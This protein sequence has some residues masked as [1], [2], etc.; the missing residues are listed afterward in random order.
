MPFNPQLTL[1]RRRTQPAA[2]Y[3]ARLTA[4]ATFAYLLALHVPAGTG[5]PVL[6]PL[7]AVLVLQASLFQTI[8]SGIKKVVSVAAGVLAA[9][10]LST[11]VEFNWWL[12]G[13]LIGAAL[14]IGH[15]L[16]LGDDILEVPIS[17]MLIFSSVGE[18]AAATGRVIDTLVGTAAGLAGGLVFAPLRVQPARE[19]VGELSGRLAELL[20]QMA[21]GLGDEPDPSRVGGWLTQARDLR[22]EIERVDDTLRQAEDSARL[23]PRVLRL[24][25]ALPETEVALRGGLETLERAALTLRFLA[26]SVIDA[27]RADSDASP[28]RDAETRDRLAAVLTRLAAAIRTYGNLVQTLPS[29]DESLQA[30]LTAELE[31]ARDVQDR[32]ADL[33]E[34]RAVPDGGATEWPL[35]GEILSHVDRLRTGL[36]VDSADSLAGSVPRHGRLLRP[37]GRP[38]AGPLAL[39]GPLAGKKLPLAGGGPRRRHGPHGAT[40]NQGKHH[41]SP[42][43]GPGSVTI[44]REKARHRAR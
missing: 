42:F 28:V 26:R 22:G 44:R 40:P 20:D 32:L 23:N 6:A 1:A 10:G 2:A 18:H 4:T 9:V 5:R 14:L 34:P 25:G 24:P 11:I 33:L 37:R 13:L 17:A 21:G 36:V 7:T 31:Q 30:E 43:Q 35:R 19:A 15:I 3:I 12:L 29:G 41:K 16:R 39:R 8:R 27:T 38:L